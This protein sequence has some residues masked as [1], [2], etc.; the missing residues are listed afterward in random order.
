MP[1]HDAGSPHNTAALLNATVLYRASAILN[2]T[3]PLQYLTTPNRAIPRRN[4]TPHHPRHTTHDLTIPL[5][6]LT[7]PNRTVQT[8]HNC[9]SP[10]LCYAGT[11][12]NDTM[13]LRN[14]TEL[15]LCRT[16][17]HGT[18]NYHDITL[19]LHNYTLPWLCEFR[20]TVPTSPDLYLMNATDPEPCKSRNP[21]LS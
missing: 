19:R 2:L 21:R 11:T 18:T 7:T 16:V 20:P 5:R 9:A 10:R 15:Y 17:L 8:Q 3:L 14:L 6:C 13:P 12:R 4:Q 1:L